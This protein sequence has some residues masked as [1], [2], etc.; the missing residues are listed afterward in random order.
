MFF[1][2]MS[3]VKTDEWLTDYNDVLRIPFVQEYLF[4]A[5]LWFTDGKIANTSSSNLNGLTGHL[6]I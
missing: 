1:E 6:S 5:R 2:V 4:L 3:T